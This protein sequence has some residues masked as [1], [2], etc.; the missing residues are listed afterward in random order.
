ASTRTGPEG[1]GVASSSHGISKASHTTWA[2]VST[3]LGETRTPAPA[4]IP[5]GLRIRNCQSGE[6]GTV[7]GTCTVRVSFCVTV[8]LREKS[9]LRFAFRNRLH[10][11]NSAAFS[12]MLPVAVLAHTDRFPHSPQEVQS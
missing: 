12:V 9:T 2:Q 1:H 6:G 5:S 8:N 11:P 7:G 3:C 10:C 4:V